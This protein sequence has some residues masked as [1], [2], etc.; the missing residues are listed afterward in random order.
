[1]KLVILTWWSVALFS[2]CSP[3]F[4]R[5]EKDECDLRDRLATEWQIAPLSPTAA[6]KPTMEEAYSHFASW[7]RREGGTLG[8]EPTQFGYLAANVD[9]SADFTEVVFSADIPTHKQGKKGFRQPYHLNLL[10]GQLKMLFLDADGN[11]RCFHTEGITISPDKRWVAFYVETIK[12]IPILPPGDAIV[13]EIEKTWLGNL[14][15]G[16]TQELEFSGSFRNFQFSSDS[17]V[18]YAQNW[19]ALDH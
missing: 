7:Y 17:Q 3:A 16:T 14:E 4:A 11:R 1:M 2:V 18:M 5:A 8:G 6:G 9:F 13:I 19:T 12:E 10:T 15:T